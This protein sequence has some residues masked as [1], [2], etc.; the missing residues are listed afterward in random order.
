MQCKDRRERIGRSYD[1]EKKIYLV[2]RMYCRDCRR[3]H[4][5]LPDFLIKYKHYEAQ[6]VEDGIEEQIPAWCNHPVPE[7]IRRW[8]IWFRH[9]LPLLNAAL[10]SVYTELEDQLPSFFRKIDY[11]EQL[12]SK[13]EGWLATVLD[14][15]INTNR[16]PEGGIP[17]G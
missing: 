4:T 15:L 2:R 14:I 1:G 12:R 7:T 6:I 11:V 9:I 8:Q 16:Y 13:G 17:A 5:E 3:M 10:A